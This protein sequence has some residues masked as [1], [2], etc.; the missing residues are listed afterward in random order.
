MAKQVTET[1]S[2]AKNYSSVRQYRARFLANGHFEQAP[3]VR[4]FLRVFNEKNFTGEFSEQKITNRGQ[5]KA[6]KEQIV[7]ALNLCA[8]LY[9]VRRWQSSLLLQPN[10]AM[11][12]KIERI[13]D[14]PLIVPLIMEGLFKNNRSVLISGAETSIQRQL[15]VGIDLEFKTIHRMIKTDKTL[16]KA[17]L[18]R[19]KRKSGFQNSLRTIGE[20]SFLP[21]KVRGKIKLIQNG[22]PFP[23]LSDAE[24]V[25][26]CLLADLCSRYDTV[27]RSFTESFHGGDQP[28]PMFSS[29][30][31]TLTIGIPPPQLIQRLMKFVDEEDQANVKTKAL[32]CGYIY[33]YLIECDK[34]SN[35]DIKDFRAQFNQMLREIVIRQR[36]QVDPKIYQRCFFLTEQSDIQKIVSTTILPIFN[37]LHQF[38][39]NE[40]ATLLAEDRVELC[41]FIIQIA[42]KGREPAPA[43]PAEET[44]E[45]PKT[46]AKQAFSK[47]MANQRKE[48]EPLLPEQLEMEKM[49]ARKIFSQIHLQHFDLFTLWNRKSEMYHLLDQPKELLNHLLSIELSRQEITNIAQRFQDLLFPYQ[50]IV[51]IVQKRIIKTIEEKEQ[52]Q[53]RELEKIYTLHSLPA[54]AHYCFDLG[55]QAIDDIERG[56]AHVLLR[57]RLGLDVSMK[58]RGTSDAT[59][60]SDSEAPRLGVLQNDPQLVAHAYAALLGNYVADRVRRFTD[61]KINHL[62]KTYRKNFFEMLYESVVVQDDIP[63]SRIQLVKFLRVHNVLANLMDKGWE[64]GSLNENLDPMLPADIL[65]GK[66]EILLPE[67]FE[68][69]EKIYQEHFQGFIKLLEEVKKSAETFPEPENPN[70]II[71]SL[72]EKGIY[73]LSS[74]EAQ[75]VFKESPFFKMFQG[76]IA[77]TS[78]KHSKHF[79]NEIMGKGANLFIPRKY[80]ELLFI[81]THFSFAIK[82]KLARFNLLFSP[83]SLKDLDPLSHIISN[84]FDQEAQKESPRKDVASLGKMIRLIRRCNRVWA[85]FSRSLTIACVD[86]ILTENSANTV[87]P[88]KILPQH[89]KVSVDDSK[90]LVLGKAS[91]S[92]QVS[93]FSM[94]MQNSQ[95]M[96]NILFHKEG[97]NITTLHE[98]AIAANKIEKLRAELFLL[99]GLAQDILDILQMLTYHTVEATLV[100]KMEISLEILVQVLSKPLRELEETDLQTCHKLAYNL[101]TLRLRLQDIRLENQDKRVISKLRDELHDRRSDNHLAKLEFSDALILLMTDVTIVQKT[102]SDGAKQQKKEME[103]EAGYQTLPQRIRET[104]KIHNILKKKKYF[105]FVPEGQIKKQVDYLLNIVHTVISLRGKSID[106]YL[107][108]T[109][110]NPLQLKEIAKLIKPTHFYKQVDLIVE[111]NP[112]PES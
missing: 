43:P 29:M 48:R 99:S 102:E 36:I 93:D 13:K 34:S 109:T 73:N 42:K 18:D 9:G 40:E 51:R 64:E 55:E 35:K 92:G 41:R 78:A 39:E 15:Q 103:V 105:I 67:E 59:L 20:L 108:T 27:I 52:Q 95:E 5:G 14:A 62:I 31:E 60:F 7:K 32:L 4:E 12:L 70:V 11:L 30:F 84:E 110:I 38:I 72:Y 79:T 94:I 57:D 104:I 81:G 76:F 37:K 23:E 107:D 58:T 80:R 69:F 83:S 25:N 1:K 68:N 100:G 2:K 63:I 71:W 66:P 96:G 33:R 16:F 89:L 8:D 106:F 21:Q 47:T 111:N 85:E 10:S 98:F 77:S 56:C 44:Q 87:G 75:Q 74:K 45:A 82:D 24:V 86:R 26:L 50:K 88:G 22:K 54:I 3:D 17:L 97:T 49:V 28:L 91:V 53:T 19:V 65:D 61:R 112:V 90:K 101:K 46:N 6:Q